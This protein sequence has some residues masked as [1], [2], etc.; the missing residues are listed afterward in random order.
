MLLF[1]FNVISFRKT[2]KNNIKVFCGF[3]FKM[4][5]GDILKLFLKWKNKTKTILIIYGYSVEF[6]Y[7]FEMQ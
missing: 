4:Y 7:L 1:V 6:R 2:I 5:N 3:L